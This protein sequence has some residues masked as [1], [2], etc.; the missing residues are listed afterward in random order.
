[1]KNS[2]DRAELKS[3][4]GQAR[5]GQ[6]RTPSEGKAVELRDLRN[7]FD[8]IGP[9]KAGGNVWPKGYSQTFEPRR[10]RKPDGPEVLGADSLE[11]KA[12]DPKG[13]HIHLE[14]V[15]GFDFSIEIGGMDPQ[16]V[17]MPVVSAH[18]HLHNVRDRKASS[19]CM[20]N[21]RR[22]ER[23]FVAPVGMVKNHRR[24]EREQG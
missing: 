4:P 3:I 1:M 16:V 21:A 11:Y 12:P 5:A 23:T 13:E 14:R 20:T 24:L 18:P 8:G 9:D 19:K 17:P 7:I 10:G 2:R 15:G 6:D 22:K